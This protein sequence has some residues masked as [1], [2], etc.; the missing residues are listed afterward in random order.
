MFQTNPEGVITVTFESVEH[1]DTAVQAMNGRIVGGNKIVAS[2]W[3]GREQFKRAETAEEKKRREN[4][5]T[6]FLENDEED[7]EANERKNDEGNV[8]I[9]GW[10]I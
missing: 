6:Q 10:F 9:D 7:G 2:H 8:Q 5:W 3:D 1:A 4:A